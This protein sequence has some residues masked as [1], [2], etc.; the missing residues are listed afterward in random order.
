MPRKKQQKRQE[1]GG[2]S[3]KQATNGKWYVRGPRPERRPLGGYDSRIDAERVLA[4]FV[5]DVELGKAGLSDPRTTP[6]LGMLAPGWFDDRAISKRSIYTD[7]NRW[8]VHLEPVLGDKRPDEVTPA[9]I[10]TEII[11]PKLRAGLSQATV[12]RIVALL[13][14]FYT[15]LVEAGKASAHPCR[16]LQRETRKLTK[17]THDPRTSPWLK[18]A[19]DIR[20]IF[21]ALP[22]PV[23]IAFAL[24]AMAGLRPGEIIALDWQQV[25]L[26]NRVIHVDRQFSTRHRVLGPP[27]GRLTRA[28]PIQGGLYPLLVDWRAR[29]GPTG[30]A[31]EMRVGY[32]GQRWQC[33]GA[34]CPP[35]SA[36]GRKARLR[37]AGERYLNEHTFPK[38][39]DQTL[40]FLRLPPLKWYNATRH[41]FASHFVSNGGS[42][43]VLQEIMGHKDFTVTQNYA[44]LRP[45]AFRHEDHDRVVVNLAPE[46]DQAP[47]RR[48]T[49]DVPRCTVCGYWPG[50]RPFVVVDGSGYHS[51]CLRKRAGEKRGNG[52]AEV[53][54]AV[55]SGKIWGNGSDEG[56]E[57]VS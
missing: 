34:V 20:R 13:S 22:E 28:V 38:Y 8:K 26:D 50:G 39:L 52:S 2:G 25:D 7:R 27:K 30:G 56:E 32:K 36:K 24:G 51:S 14:V 55:H 23:N 12:G 21:L 57:N 44:H 4:K 47:G 3:I 45:D 41:T 43:E 5:E 16:Q 15:D 53:H 35:A 19:G 46:G 31:V 6:T 17:S 18:D 40:A 42:L 37:P 49:G 9:F 33:S 11:M 10:R 54:D 1:Y 48:P 29:R